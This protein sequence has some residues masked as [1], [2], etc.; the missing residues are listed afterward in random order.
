[1][2]FRDVD[3]AVLIVITHINFVSLIIEL[4]YP[5]LSYSQNVA[6]EGFEKVILFFLL[7]SHSL[8]EKM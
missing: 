7:L 1:M 6:L 8:V 3:V 2:V 4:Y 5:Y